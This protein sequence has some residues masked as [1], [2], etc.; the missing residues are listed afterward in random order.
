[1]SRD[2]WMESNSS[3]MSPKPSSYTLAADSSLKNVPLT[4]STSTMSPFREVDTVKY[5]GAYLDQS[6]NFKKTCHHQMQGS[7]D[8]HSKNQ[9]DQETPNQRDMSSTHALTCNISPRL[10]QWN[11]YRMPRHHTNPHAEGAEH[12]SKNGAKQTSEP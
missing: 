2:G 10:W 8:Q 3:S 12:S 7:N 6:L 11:S 4:E 5:L 9:N 1:M